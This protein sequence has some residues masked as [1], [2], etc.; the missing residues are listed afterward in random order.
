MQKNLSN[1]LALAKKAY[2]SCRS[3]FHEYFE[4]EFI[5]NF[6]VNSIKRDKHIINKTNQQTLYDLIDNSVLYRLELSTLP[7]DKT[8][9]LYSFANPFDAAVSLDELLESLVYSAF[10]ASLVKEYKDA[11]E[12]HIYDSRIVDLIISRLECKKS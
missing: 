2:M 12:Q 10:P 4:S 9:L 1:I 6:L 8:D 11:L 3:K 5:R 7:P